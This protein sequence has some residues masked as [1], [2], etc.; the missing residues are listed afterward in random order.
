MPF[1]TQG[2]LWCLPEKFAS[3]SNSTSHHTLLSIV[4]T[5]QVQKDRKALLACQ[6]AIIAALAS[7]KSSGKGL[8]SSVAR[9]AEALDRIVARRYSLKGCRTIEQVNAKRLGVTLPPR[10][11]RRP[12]DDVAR[13]AFEADPPT[14]AHDKIVLTRDECSPYSVEQPPSTPDSANPPPDDT[15]E[16]FQKE[17]L[18]PD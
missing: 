12:P 15:T 13:P 11:A 7:P 16:D 2:N 17:S 3:L 5:S 1:L 4:P 10:G 18:S 8:L 14:P 9:A 6:N